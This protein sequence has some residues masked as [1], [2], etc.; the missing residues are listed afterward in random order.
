MHF[1]LNKIINLWS[2]VFSRAQT[3]EDPEMTPENWCSVQPCTTVKLPSK[4]IIIT[5]PLSTFWVYLLGVLTI[6]VGLY[7]FWIQDNQNS[8]FYWG[9]SLLLWGIGALLAGTSYQAFGYEIKCAGRKVC[10]WTSWW[11]IIYLMFQQVSMNALLAAVAYSCTT[12]TFRTVLLGYVLFSSIAYVLLVFIGGILPLK[13]LITFE[14][15]VWFSTPGIVACIFLNAIRLFIY[16]DTMDLAL[17]GTWILLVLTMAA[18]WSYYKRGITKKLW[19][20][21][22]WFSENDVLHV[23]LIIWMIYI[24]VI[25]ANTIKDHPV[26]FP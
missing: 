15:M 2:A 24:A 1:P 10:A 25:V 12:G 20:G 17:L 5:Q 16:G 19:A 6:C 8:R 14:F 13:S 21:K 7:F 18:Y 26:S 9:V 3:I 11:E 4:E 23:L 22:T